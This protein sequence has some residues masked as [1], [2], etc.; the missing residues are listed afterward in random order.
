MA[1]SNYIY[2]LRYSGTQ[3]PGILL[4]L[5]KIKYCS[6]LLRKFIMQSYNDQNVINMN[7]ITYETLTGTWWF[8][9]ISY[10]A[11]LKTCQLRKKPGNN[12]SYN[13]KLIK[14]K[15]KENSVYIHSISF[16]HV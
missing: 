14:S 10:S 12:I 6:N 5:D 9:L 16:V 2:K 8:I 15:K 13:E 11:L 3:L 4:S 1:G 7:K